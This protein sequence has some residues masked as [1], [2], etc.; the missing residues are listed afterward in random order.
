MKNLILFLISSILF[1]CN[2]D[3]KN[4]VS[5]AVANN[6]Q[7]AMEEITSQFE[8]KYGISVEVSSGSSGTLTSQI[9]QGAPYDVFISANMKYPKSLHNDKLTVEAPKIYAYGSLVFWTLKDVD[10]NEGLKS[11]LN[12]NIKKIAIANPET[13]PY[14]IAAVE[15]LKNA[16]LHEILNSKII[17][18][19]GVSQVNQYVKSGAVDVGITSKSVVYSPK[20]VEKGTYIDVDKTLYNQI[21]QGIVILKKGKETNFKNAELFYNFMFTSEVKIILTKFGYDSKTLND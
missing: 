3:N 4:K 19:E 1:S 15:A 11:L 14:G 7:F 16:K 8:E 12:D 6:M 9:K 2:S 18:G 21:E 17:Y 13:A 5:I 10:I 20:L